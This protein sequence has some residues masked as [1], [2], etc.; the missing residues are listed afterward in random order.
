MKLYQELGFYVPASF[1]LKV[2]TSDSIEDVLN[3]SYERTFSHELIHFLQ[4]VTTT[5]GLINICSCVDVLKDQNQIALSANGSL[6]TPISINSYSQSVSTNIDLFSCYVGDGAG[7]FMEFPDNVKIVSVT[8]E[9]MEVDN[10][11]HG[12]S[13]IEIEY[14]GE[15]YSSTKKFHFGAMAICESM[16]HLIECEIY[17]NYAKKLNFPYD[18]A[19]MLVAHL[20]PQLMD[21]NQAISEICEA[22]L[23]YYNPAEVFIKAL[24][25][26]NKNQVEINKSNGFYSY[27]LNTFSLEESRVNDIFKEV[28]QSAM[29]QLN[30]L[31]T[32]EPLKSE[33]WASSLVGKGSLL[34]NRGCCLTALLWNGDQN[35]KRV[36]LMETI[37]SIGFPVA[38]NREDQ[39][40]VQDSEQTLHTPLLFPAIM[41]ISEIFMGKSY[42]CSLY[43][44]C[45]KHGNYDVGGECKKRPWLRS[46]NDDLCYFSSVWRM[47]GLDKIEISEQ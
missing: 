38:F 33:C 23:M 18:S 4:D 2:N 40:W 30:D 21:N 13:V 15:G 10:V 7:K 32:V 22:S 46:N 11:S 12:I 3:S 26:I 19:T 27:V 9:L 5:Y 1:M 20:C 16:A 35:H 17:G 47:W 45:N 31:F 34:R 8:E 42:E 37:K 6:N 43:E 39:V 24:K 41:S 44:Y 36:T 29:S 14:G 25:E 28:T